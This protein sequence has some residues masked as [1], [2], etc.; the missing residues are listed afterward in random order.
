MDESTDTTDNAQ[1]MVFVRYCEESKREF[2]ED[3]L[4]MANLC[5]QTRGEDIHNA[6]LEML[7]E[8][9]I[10]VKKVVS[11]A[12][13]GA[14]AIMGRERGLVQR[15]KVLHPILPLRNSPVCPLCKPWRNLL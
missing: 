9:G 8:K 6:V 11:V 12:T 7:K 10:D 1:L 14:P 4:G 13:D 15:L 5:G 2:V 3:V